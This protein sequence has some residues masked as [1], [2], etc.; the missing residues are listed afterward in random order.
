MRL[1]LSNQAMAD[2]T[3]IWQY[4]AAD[5]PE[6]ADRFVD[7]IYETCQGLIAHPEMG[8]RRDELLPQLRSLPVKRY[9]I[10]YRVRE[11][12]IEIVRVLSAYRD[13]GSLF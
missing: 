9:V 2:L 5:N 4:V 10:F 8:R 7:N 11:A 12:K 1:I 6:A 13:L 3:D